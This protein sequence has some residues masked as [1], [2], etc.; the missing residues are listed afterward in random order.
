MRSEDEIRF[1]HMLD[2]A[3]EAATFFEGKDRKSLSKN[4]MLLLATVKELE[5]IGE[6]AAK[7]SQETKAMYPDIPWPDII[8]MRHRLIH[9]YFE[10][11]IEVVWQTI[12]HDIPPL[13]TLLNSALGNT[14]ILRKER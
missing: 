7:V 1:R 2:A 6:A 8:G 3:H 9:A 4:R 11:D 14:D 5:I 10:I 12:A 13:I